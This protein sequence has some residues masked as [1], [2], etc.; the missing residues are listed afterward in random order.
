MNFTDLNRDC[1]ANIIS[2]LDDLCFNKEKRLFL[3]TQFHLINK[4]CNTLHKKYSKKCNLIFYKKLIHC[5]CNENYFKKHYFSLFKKNEIKETVIKTL[6]NS[7]SNKKKKFISTI[8]FNTEEEV[9]MANRYLNEFGTISH[10]CCGGLG[11]MYKIPD[12]I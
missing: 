11:V 4:M 5:N 7:K 3:T 8:H 9:R 6:I 12:I 1:F 10:R 2:Y